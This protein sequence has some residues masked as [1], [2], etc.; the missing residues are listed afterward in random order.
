MTG[1]KFT[2]MSTA[3]PSPKL[4]DTRGMVVVHRV[5]RRELRL[6]PP[7]VDAVP[8]GDTARSERVARHLVEMTTALHDHHTGED[9]LL[10]PRLRRRVPAADQL[11]DRMA[12]EHVAI[13]EGLDAARH[14]T[15]TWRD[16]ADDRQARQLVALLQTTSAALDRHLGDEERLVLPLVERHIT[17]AEWEE[18][19]A[20]GMGSIPRSRLPVFLGHILED[21]DPAE[22]AAFLARVPVAGRVLYRLVGRRRYK[23]ETRALRD[24]LP[25]DWRTNLPTKGR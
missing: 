3:G 6:L 10:W 20:H 16:T 8:A 5:F 12:L 24:G 18:L 2:E 22:R 19:A 21:A 15:S 14:L 1:E 17:N 11:L 9:R 13:A 4:C 7:M 25:R 23:R